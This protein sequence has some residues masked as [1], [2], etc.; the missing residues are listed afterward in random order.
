MTYPTINLNS[1]ALPQALP[2]TYVIAIQ[3]QTKAI[4]DLARLLIQLQSGTK[5]DAEELKEGFEALETRQ[6]AS[7]LAI[8]SLMQAA[9]RAV[10]PSGGAPQSQAESGNKER[11]V[12][13]YE[14][15]AKIETYAALHDGKFDGAT[16]AFLWVQELVENLLLL[17][18]TEIETNCPISVDTIDY[19]IDVGGL[20][21][22]QAFLLRN[23][24]LSEHC[25][26]HYQNITRGGSLSTSKERK[27]GYAMHLLMQPLL[28]RPQVFK[29]MVD[30]YKDGAIAKVEALV[31]HV[32]AVVAQQPNKLAHLS[33]WNKPLPE[34]DPNDYPKF[35]PDVGLPVKNS[36]WEYPFPESFKIYTWM[37]D[38]KKEELLKLRGPMKAALESNPEWQKLTAPLKEEYAHIAQFAKVMGVRMNSVRHLQRYFKPNVCIPTLP[39][40]IDDPNNLPAEPSPKPGSFIS[41][42]NDRSGWPDS[43]LAKEE[44]MNP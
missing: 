16:N 8:D 34:L 19:W 4:S 6:R 5:R 31:T 43:S 1:L 26:R 39:L 13:M 38:R 20:P 9:R 32:N 12:K 36:W 23:Y 25:M 2:Q 15:S 11:C 40:L 10:L 37:N 27:A 21:S 42:T 17:S 29:A 41:W 18:T 28:I 7:E 44:N 30:H 33:I 3:E 24:P 35:A 22:E 14:L